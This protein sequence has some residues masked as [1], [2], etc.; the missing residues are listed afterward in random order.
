[1]RE[2]YNQ[3]LIEKPDHQGRVD[4]DFAINISGT[5]IRGEVRNQP[6]GDD[7]LEQNVLVL[8][9]FRRLAKCSFTIYNRLQLISTQYD[10][11]AT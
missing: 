7:E 6:P 2:L 8:L 3:R 1:M 4:I 5:V 9:K 11:T 10:R